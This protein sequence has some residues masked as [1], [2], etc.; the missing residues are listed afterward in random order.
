MSSLSEFQNIVMDEIFL[1]TIELW[2][3]FPYDKIAWVYEN[4]LPDASLRRFV[5]DFAVKNCS[6]EA[7]K[8]K[9]NDP[10]RLEI[11]PKEW[12]RDVVLALIT[13][14]PFPQRSH[15][16]WYAVDKSTYHVASYNE[17]DS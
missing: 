8:K 14:A 15:K 13:D 1:K 3:M 6:R 4:T 12:Y 16:D 2:Q 17:T 9:M 10:V 5:V 11:L 7:L